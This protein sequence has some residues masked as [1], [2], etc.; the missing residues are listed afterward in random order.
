MNGCDGNGQMASCEV[1]SSVSS[2]K[3]R[4]EVPVTVRSW[5][6]SIGVGTFAGFEQ[7]AGKTARATAGSAVNVTCRYVP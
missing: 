6:T 5:M 1:P 4:R 3:M 7:P 2:W